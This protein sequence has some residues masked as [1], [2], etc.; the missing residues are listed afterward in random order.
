MLMYV[1]T[2][3]SIQPAWHHQ[4]KFNLCWGIGRDT[5]GQKH[6]D[7]VARVGGEK[8]HADNVG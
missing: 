5:E 6:A 1:T 4:Q 7:N 2:V 8:K 3:T